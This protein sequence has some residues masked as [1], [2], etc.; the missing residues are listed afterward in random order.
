MSW[1]QSPQSA[2]PTRDPPIRNPSSHCGTDLLFFHPHNF[3]CS[4]V[5]RSHIRSLC[6]P[7]PEFLNLPNVALI[8]SCCGKLPSFGRWFYE[9][10]GGACDFNWQGRGGSD[11]K[12]GALGPHPKSARLLRNVPIERFAP[13]TKP[14]M[15]ALRGEP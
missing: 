10:K 11:R 4:D 2:P 6:E 9:V 14:L 8:E 15:A 3:L 5:N 12:T 7:A 13:F 1:V